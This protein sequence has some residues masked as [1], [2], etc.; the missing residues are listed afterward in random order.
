MALMDA[1]IEEARRRAM[2]E[3]PNA[4]P[5]DVRAYIRRLRHG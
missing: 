5:R 2:A 1:A 4:T 3:N